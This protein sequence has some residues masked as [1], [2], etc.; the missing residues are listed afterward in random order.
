MLKNGVSRSRKDS[1]PAMSDLLSPGPKHPPELGAVLAERLD[2]A[3]GNP[4]S[5]CARVLHYRYILIRRCSDGYR[6]SA[7]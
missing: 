6:L 4:E 3:T 7:K 5:V 1:Y 2:Y